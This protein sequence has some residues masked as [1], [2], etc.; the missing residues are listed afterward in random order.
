MGDIIFE[1]KQF[2][3]YLFFGLA[4]IG[5]IYAIAEGIKWI[6]KIF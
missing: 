1:V 3:K 5:L 6:I 2:F 4:Y